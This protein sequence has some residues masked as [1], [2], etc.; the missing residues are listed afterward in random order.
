MDEIFTT[1]PSGSDLTRLTSN[2][3]D[4]NPNFSPDGQRIAFSRNR[5]RH[6]K[7]HTMAAD[8]SDEISI[9]NNIAGPCRDLIDDFDPAFSP[10]G[11]RIAF[12][13]NRE[14]AAGRCFSTNFDIY[15]VAPDGSGVVRLT[16]NAAFDG[17]P[18]W[19]PL[20][21]SPHGRAA[22]KEACK[23]EGWRELGFRNHGQCVRAANKD[24]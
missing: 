24:G 12:G 10:D 2:T 4:A 3:A 18:D 15:A 11:E 22:G 9:T 23:N 17:D 8:G 16:N 6:H 21:R 5:F 7:I 13:S 14:D 19:Q 20:P 1:R